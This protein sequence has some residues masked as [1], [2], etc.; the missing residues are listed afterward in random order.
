MGSFSKLMLVT[1]KALR[2]PNYCCLPY[3]RT[4]RHNESF[5]FSLIKWWKGLPLKTRISSILGI[6][7]RNLLKCLHFLSRNYLFYIGDRSASTSHTCLRLNFGALN[8]QLF[9]T[10]CCPSPACALCDA[11]AKGAKHY[12]LHVLPKFCCSA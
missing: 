8:Y 6:F 2:S 5:L 12:S 7:E 3:V 9:Q 4:D 1:T 10:N 11:P